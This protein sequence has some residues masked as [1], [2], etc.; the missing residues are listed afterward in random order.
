MTTKDVLE[1]VNHLNELY[2]S[3]FTTLITIVT[4][5][6][7]FIGIALPILLTWY[8]NR[9]LQLEASMLESTVLSKIR[10]EL[11]ALLRPYI[12]KVA[13]DIHRISRD[14]AGA[15][16]HAQGDKAFGEA[17]FV[18]AIVQYCIATYCYLDSENHLN[19]QRS[20]HQLKAC[21]AEIA[22]NLALTIEADQSR[23]IQKLIEVLKVYNQAHG[24]IYL[25]SYYELLRNYSRL[26]PKPLSTEE[27]GDVNVG[28]K[29]DSFVLDVPVP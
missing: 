14:N 6:L 9:R 21:A 4:I 18:E 16:C 17:Q 12:L 27:L 28:F 13:G 19:A 15:H 5:V 8:Q 22:K 2:S 24:N 26:V 3:L 25:D 29:A 10:K 11:P 7:A 23:D 1:I 20:L